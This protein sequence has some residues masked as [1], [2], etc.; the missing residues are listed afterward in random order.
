MGDTTKFGPVLR[1]Q[2]G[3]LALPYEIRNLVPGTFCV[4]APFALPYAMPHTPRASRRLFF[5]RSGVILEDPVDD[6]TDNKFL[7]IGFDTKGNPLEV[8][9]NRIDSETIKVFHAMR[10][11]GALI[12][13]LGL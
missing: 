2:Q 5:R 8:M 10:C 3:T 13:Q 9:Y 12:D 1:K 11:R 6:G 7:L 4:A